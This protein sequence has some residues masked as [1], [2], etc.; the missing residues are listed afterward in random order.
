MKSKF[1]DGKYNR[2]F[3]YLV[4]ML[5]RSAGLYYWFW[6]EKQQTGLEG[7]NLEASRCAEIEQIFQK[8]TRDSIEQFDDMQFHVA[9][10]TKSGSFYSINLTLPTSTCPDFLCIWFCKHI[11]A[12]YFHFPHM[13]PCWAPT[14]PLAPSV[15]EHLPAQCM[16][17]KTFHSLVQ[18]VNN[19]SHQLISDQTNNLALSPATL[20]AIHSAKVSLS[21]AIALVNGS[22][23][24]PIKKKLVTDAVFYHL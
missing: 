17:S 14:T 12:I 16:S 1:F 11:G 23:P 21:T 5:M 3:D 13:C 4:F 20:E 8:I 19:L 22:S 18:D 15:P 2:H 24:L 9:S 7:L 10:Q 6:H